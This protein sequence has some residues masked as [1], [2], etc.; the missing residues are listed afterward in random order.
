MTLDYVL[1]HPENQYLV[2]QQEKL[3][4]FSEERRIDPEAFPARTFRSNDV[5]TTRYFSDGLP[6]FLSNGRSSPSFVYVDDNQLTSAAPFGSYL[7][8][9]FPLFRA[10]RAVE[11]IFLPTSAGRFTIAQKTLE[12]FLVR[13]REIG[14]PALDLGRLLRHFPHRRLH[15]QKATRGLT[16]AQINALQDDLH[17]LT[18]PV[19]DHF[20][21][22]WKRGGA[23]GLHAEFSMQANASASPQL[24]LKPSILEHNYDFFGTLHA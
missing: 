4:Y 7:E 20:Y 5:F 22:I 21:G 13:A 1:E 15:E 6:Q 10:L 11:I 24:R 14:A 3:S 23:D 8:T 12:R 19:V 18:G 16:T 9:Y 17:F 2:T